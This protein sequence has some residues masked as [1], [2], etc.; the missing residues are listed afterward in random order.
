MIRSNNF[1]LYLIS[2]GILTLL[3]INSSARAEITKNTLKGKILFLSSKGDAYYLM[4]ANGTNITKLSGIEDIHSPVLSPYGDKI[5]W[6]LQSKI[7][8]RH[9]GG[10][11]C[12]TD[13]EVKNKKILDVIPDADKEYNWPPAYSLLRW[14]KDGKEVYFYYTKGALKN[15]HISGQ[16]KYEMAINVETGSKRMVKEIKHD[17]EPIEELLTDCKR[18]PHYSADAQNAIVENF[19]INVKTGNKI[20]LQPYN[21]W[22]GSNYVKVSWAPNSKKLA[23]IGGYDDWNIYIINADGTNKKNLTNYVY[24]GDS[25]F[26]G[27][28]G[29]STPSWSADSRYIC[30]MYSSGATPGLEFF[31]SPKNASIVIIDTVTGEKIELTE[32][33]SPIWLPEK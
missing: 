4:N 17:A 22:T 25:K 16:E 2:I 27:G 6:L 8:Y 30:C 24:Y 28:Y 19:I 29:R 21:F 13:S 20:R 23:F 7:G 11:I 1:K 14:S 3:I 10:G 32:G 15:E 5:V 31:S 26:S 12:V 9:Q 18:G 33:R